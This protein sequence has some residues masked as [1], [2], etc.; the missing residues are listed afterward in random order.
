M[1]ADKG[2]ETVLPSGRLQP[3][4]VE[5]GRSVGTVE[6]REGRE[7]C[8]IRVRVR[9]WGEASGGSAIRTSSMSC[10]RE[11]MLLAVSSWVRSSSAL[12]ER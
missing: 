10:R 2:P 6:E 12:Q 1:K 11:T 4:S 5:T 7:R 9:E 3:I 8:G